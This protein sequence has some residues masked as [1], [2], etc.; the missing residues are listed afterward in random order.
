MA[1]NTRDDVLLSRGPA[2]ET[3]LIVRD[4]RT[5]V[6]KT[7]AEHVLESADARRDLERE[8]RIVRQLDARGVPRF[9]DAGQEQGRPFLLMEHWAGR[10]LAEID[11]GACR[12]HFPSLVRGAFAALA[13]VHEASDA[14][15]PLEVVHGD[16]SGSNVLVAPR[17]DRCVVVDFQLGSDRDGGPA[18]DGA[19]RGT[20]ATV[21]PEVAQGNVPDAR[22]DIFAMAVSLL[23]AVL[24][25]E[26]RAS[27]LD[28]AVRLAL[29][30][31]SRIEIDEVLL[32]TWAPAALV[33][34][35]ERC[36]SH[37]PENRP[38]T[39]REVCDAARP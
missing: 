1:R 31:E 39:A 23:N 15:G 4:G 35:L 25:E 16:V 37:Q 27:G 14:R 18:H 20:L 29:A 7:L 13:D 21:A 9:V 22:S 2:T 5:L 36:V 11:R 30:G 8:T 3:R 12:M 38:R 19:F 28:P 32:S 33:A 6:M 10:A 34:V 26:L 17:F 24:P